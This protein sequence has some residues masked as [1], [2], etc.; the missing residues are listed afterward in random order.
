MPTEPQGELRYRSLRCYWPQK[1]A[2]RREF[3]RQSENQ[4]YIE[5]LQIRKFYGEED[6]DTSGE[7]D[8]DEDDDVPCEDENEA[9]GQSDRTENNRNGH[10]DVE[11]RN[12][13][14]NVRLFMTGMTGD[15][16]TLQYLD[17]VEL[18]ASFVEQT[19]LREL[20]IKPVRDTDPERVVLLDDRNIGDNVR[21]KKGYCRP[22]HG[23]MTPQELHAELSKKVLPNFI[24]ELSSRETNTTHSVSKSTRNKI[25][26][27]KCLKMSKVMRRGE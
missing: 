11:V 3:S 27:P 13:D 9:E 18:V 20:E 6:E 1:F 10:K 17:Q 15:D 14:S 21:E 19:R 2:K 4:P 5:F 25:S 12:G 24:L 26:L 23:P 7:E 8:E 16:D 22:Y